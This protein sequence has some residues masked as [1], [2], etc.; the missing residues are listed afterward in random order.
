MPKRS[1]TR[2]R[3]QR[4]GNVSPPSAWGNVFDTAGDGWTQFMNTLSLN[5][6]NPSQS[7]LLHLKNTSRSGINANANAR[8]MK[9]GRKTRS[10]RGGN[11]AGVLGQGA[12]PLVLLGMNQYAKR[13]SSKVKHGRRNRSFKR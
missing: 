5:N 2:S 1:K 10:R 8:T 6:N 13:Y 3:G 4:G 7:N 11:F 12:A 9:G